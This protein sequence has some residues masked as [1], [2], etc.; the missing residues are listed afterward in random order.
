MSSP[1]GGSAVE[2]T[3]PIWRSEPR[4]GR[5]GPFATDRWSGCG[6]STATVRPW[7]L[8]GCTS[9]RARLISPASR[10]LVEA[11]RLAHDRTAGLDP[12]DLASLE[13]ARAAA[14]DVVLV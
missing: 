6:G 5:S 14:R 13:V 12:L 4:T 9:S 10:G 8:A 2:S 7:K 11:L 1:S 3:P